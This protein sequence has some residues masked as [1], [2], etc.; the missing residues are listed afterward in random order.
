VARYDF[1]SPR[2]HVVAPLASG[3][4]VALDRQQANYLLNV[5]RLR[6]GETVLVFN[7]RDGE[8]QAS[9]TSPGRRTP[10]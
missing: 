6:A 4:S 3:V 10:R 5:L 7:G 1:R 9:V 8:W 2:L